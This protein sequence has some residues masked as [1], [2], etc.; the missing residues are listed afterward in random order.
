MNPSEIQKEIGD[1]KQDFQT[2]LDAMDFK[3]DLEM[4][5]SVYPLLPKENLIQSEQFSELKRKLEQNVSRGLIIDSISPAI[6]FDALSVD[7]NGFYSF[8]NR[9]LYGSV[10][11]RKNGFIIYNLHY[12]KEHSNQRE[13][14]QTY[15]MAA[16]FLGFLELLTFFYS[17]VNY[18]G[19]LK[20]IYDVLKIHDWKYSP[21]PKY[22][23]Y[24]DREFNSTRFTPIEKTIHVKSLEE[25]ENKFKLVEDI[26]SE[27]ILGYGEVRRYK[28]PDELKRQY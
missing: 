16:Y 15:Y 27:M 2:K 7:Q 4:R 19:E 20:I 22:L 6:I 5:I 1:I 8:S 23:P 26:F 3:R 28:V 17:Y 25:L 24:D 18:I 9:E 13:V 10:I 14:L 21:Y 11:I 12:N